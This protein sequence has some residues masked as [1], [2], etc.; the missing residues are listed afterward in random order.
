[1]EQ[2]P[3][4]VA[5]LFYPANPTLLQSMMNEWISAFE[6]LPA[7]AP[8]ALIAPHAGYMYSGPIAA[9]AYRQVVNAH[10]V[11]RVVLLGPAHRL[12]FGGHA[13]S[14]ARHFMTPLGPV[15]LDRVAI[16]QLISSGLARINDPAH[17]QEHALEVQ[18]PFLQ[19][20]LPQPFVV[21]PI[22]VGSSD[23]QSV[24]TMLEMLWQSESDLVIVSSDLSHY[25][26]YA[27]AQR[28]DQEA[29]ERILS[30]QE[31]TH[32]QACGATPINGLLQMARRRNWQ[33]R[34]L[35]LRNSGDTAGD[36]DRVV[37]YAALAFEAAYA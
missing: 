25:L 28:H 16:Q 3:A 26:D 6:T 20:C 12:G 30:G 27:T 17:A 21:I 29:I 13:V 23:P 15:A 35:D 9:S 8:M 7:L 24:A 36:R 22:L 4:A 10:H 1:M 34:L 2:R 37:G 14:S 18:L 5:G 31:L 33:P 32:D 11:R 19:R